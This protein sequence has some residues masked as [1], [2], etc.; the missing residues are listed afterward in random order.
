ML[1]YTRTTASCEINKLDGCLINVF[2]GA[3]W[4]KPITF[5]GVRYKWN[6]KQQKWI[7][8]SPC[9]F[10]LLW[11]KERNDELHHAWKLVCAQL[12]ALRN[13]LYIRYPHEM[14]LL[15]MQLFKNKHKSLRMFVFDMIKRITFVLSRSCKNNEFWNV[16]GF[17][18]WRSGIIQHM[19]T[20]G[21]SIL[22]K[23]RQ[24]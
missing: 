5:N 13:I 21:T 19:Q 12:S 23:W 20:P 24:K 8:V 18:F 6:N 11:N 10:A 7:S 4:D 16:G 17:E 22:K 2:T 15:Q 9:H 3:R 14:Q 1:K